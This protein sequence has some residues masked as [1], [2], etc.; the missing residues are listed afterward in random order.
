MGHRTVD[1]LDLLF[2]PLV[3]CLR[4]SLLVFA[5][6]SRL[7]TLTSFA[8]SYAFDQG[9]SS[10]GLFQ[11]ALSWALYLAY[12]SLRIFMLTTFWLSEATTLLSRFSCLLW[13]AFLFWPKFYYTLFWPS[14]KGRSVWHIITDPKDAS[15]RSLKKKNFDP[16]TRISPLWSRFLVF[17]SYQVHG[18]YAH[19]HQANHEE[20]AEATSGPTLPRIW[21][22]LRLATP[23]NIAQRRLFKPPDCYLARF[24]SLAIIVAVYTVP[25][26]R[27]TLYIIYLCLRTPP[28]VLH[29]STPLPSSAALATTNP[30]AAST[31]SVT[32]DTDGIPFIIDNSA[33]CII[34]NVRSLFVGE[35]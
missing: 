35:L 11:E 25:L 34:C 14:A 4:M 5:L 6:S 19:L 17:S 10:G 23:Y 3:L 27:A 20:V 1:K 33:T 9:C 18:A 16:P 30:T 21:D 7:V 32:F 31:P 13:Q 22:P 12:V 2:I 26:T 29:S 15:S 24:V 8:Y 28:Q